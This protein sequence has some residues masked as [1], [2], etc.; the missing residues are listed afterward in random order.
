MGVKTNFFV[1]VFEVIFIFEVILFFGIVLIF[2]VVFIFEDVFIFEVVFSFEVV[3][4]F[5]HIKNSW[6][7]HCSAMI[8][9]LS[10]AL[11]SQA[12]KSERGTAQPS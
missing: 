4:I 9:N 7:W 6:V 12:K 2:E 11:F 5:S 1:C 10:V 3:F 8:K